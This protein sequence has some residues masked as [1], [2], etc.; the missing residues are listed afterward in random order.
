MCV[1]VCVRE[2]E[3]EGEEE[4]EVLVDSRR[5]E[6]SAAMLRDPPS[7][8][9]YREVGLPSLTRARPHCASIAGGYRAFGLKRHLFKPN[10][11]CKF[12]NIPE[13]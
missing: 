13:T 5:L 7:P 2:R 3:R 9:S 4:G 10:V 1:C 8:W 11:Y 12:N 6:S